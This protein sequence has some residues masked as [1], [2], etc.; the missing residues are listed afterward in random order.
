V[1]I[2]VG[3][4]TRLSYRNLSPAGGLVNG[5]VTLTITM[6]D[7]SSSG[8]LTP[9]NDSTGLYHYDYVTTQAGKHAVRWVSAGANVAA[10]SGV[11]DVRPS[12]PAY[13]V[14]LDD[15]KAQLNI[16]DTS[17]DDE[18]RAY[19]EATTTVI[20]TYLDKA[21]VRR[22]VTERR[23]LGT[24]AAYSPPGSIQRFPLLH[25]PVISLTS[26][27]SA[28]GGMSWSPAA[29]WVSDAGVVEVLSGAVVWGPVSIV[30]EAGMTQVPA[31]Y[32]LAARMV[33]QHL[34]RT[35][36]GPRG[37][38]PGGGDLAAAGA[39]YV[40]SYQVRELLGDPVSG[41]A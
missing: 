19:L 41:I 33:V 5:T 21:I 13:L 39:T 6:P 2:D 40:T 7:G 28:D 34:W 15:A 4:Q 12:A 37:T 18:L 11:F 32:G 10:E 30:Y 22:T 1:T 26:I 36:R 35:Q 17:V 8:P 29:M 31:N 23:N 20:E 3:D 14:S 38:V 9:V 24:P 16:T 25:T 27:T